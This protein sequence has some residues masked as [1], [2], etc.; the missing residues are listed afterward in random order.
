MSCLGHESIDVFIT[1]RNVQ[2][3]ALS[4]ALTG[5]PDVTLGNT[6]GNITIY[7]IHPL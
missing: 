6:R 7:G 3:E 5:S 2:Y 4:V 1:G